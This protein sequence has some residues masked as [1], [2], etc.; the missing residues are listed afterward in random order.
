MADLGGPL[1]EVEVHA[2]L[3]ELEVVER[4]TKPTISMGRWL[5]WGPGQRL[6][7]E[8]LAQ[9]LRDARDPAQLGRRRRHAWTEVSEWLEAPYGHAFP[10]GYTVQDCCE[11]CGL[12]IESVLRTFQAIREA[13][14]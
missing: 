8:V 11:I 12:S 1:T 5:L 14:S 2:E 4:P 3:A 7:A 13:K 6:A 9:A 10:H